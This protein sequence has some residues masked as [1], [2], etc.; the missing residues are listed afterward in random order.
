MIGESNVPTTSENDMPRQIE[1]LAER[2]GRYKR[3]AYFFLYRALDYTLKKLKAP[4]HVTGQE[5][6]RGISEFARKEYGP[7]TKL[8]FE[9]WGIA[10]TEDFGNIVFTLVESGLMGKTEEDRI[11][12][13][14]EVYDFDEEFG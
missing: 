12:D 9:Y 14:R 6:L 5:L 8:V 7:M 10:R 13:F 2:D 1:E 11:E 4:R 3:E